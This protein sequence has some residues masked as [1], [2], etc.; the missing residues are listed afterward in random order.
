MTAYAA[1]RTTEQEAT[2]DRL[3]VICSVGCA[4]HCAATPVLLSLLPSYRTSG[5][6][7]NPLFHQVVAA[8]CVLLVYRAIWPTWQLHRDRLVATTASAGIAL[9]CVSSFVLPTCCVGGP[10]ED[11]RHSE[12]QAALVSPL[13]LSA[14]QA[15]R[16]ASVTESSTHVMTFASAGLP[17][18]CS[19]PLL[20]PDDLHRLFGDAVSFQLLG[21]QPYFNPLGGCLLIIAHVL[22][23]RHRRHRNCGC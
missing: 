6:L 1:K 5:W 23:A 8:I 3:G 19:R 10:V 4:L 20:Q 18:F 13:S 7:S 12:P 11:A 9:V 2:A 17:Q 16:V 22:N 21:M 14:A 15:D